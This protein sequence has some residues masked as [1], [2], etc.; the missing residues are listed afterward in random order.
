MM[1]FQDDALDGELPQ[2]G[3]MPAALRAEV[4]SARLQNDAMCSA[5]AS[6]LLGQQTDATSECLKAGIARCESSN[7]VATRSTGADLSDLANVAEWSSSASDMDM[8]DG[9]F[10]DGVVSGAMHMGCPQEASCSSSLASAKFWCNPEE[11]I[12]FLDFDDTIFP[13][14]WLQDLSSE[15]CQDITSLDELRAYDAAAAANMARLESVAISFLRTA[16]ALAG[17]VVIV[18]LGRECWIER[19]LRGFFPNLRDELSKLSIGVSYAREALPKR[20]VRAAILEGMDVYSLM[21]R[22]AMKSSITKFYSKRP[23]QSWKNCISIG[24]STIERDALEDLT[25]T[26]VQ[27]SKSGKQKT[28]RSKTVKFQYSPSVDALTSEI[29]LMVSCLS[30]L[31]HYDG[32]FAYEIQ[33]SDATEHVSLHELLSQDA[34]E[35][36]DFH[37]K[38]M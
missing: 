21:K 15:A 37:S 7:S 31:T 23:K 11:T 38:I 32:D 10:P 5:L 20:K 16:A 4:A 14:T 33:E 1:T 3:K 22:A 28:V 34:G 2:V 35:Q 27:L 13:T 29:E 12:V 24:D 25:F 18:T 36:T 30:A 6:H 19:C 26:R 8:L 9:S 17:E